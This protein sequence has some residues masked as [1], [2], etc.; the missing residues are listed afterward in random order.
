MGEDVRV[1]E[2]QQLS[3]LLYIQLSRSH[4]LWLKTTVVDPDPN[5]VASAS[6]CRI[7]IGPKPAALDR[8]H[9]QNH[10]C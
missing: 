7:W 8:M 3:Q 6:F 1:N 4:L 9:V 10:A 5:P 2:V